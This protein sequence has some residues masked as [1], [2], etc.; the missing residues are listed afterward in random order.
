[1]SKIVQDYIPIDWIFKGTPDMFSMASKEFSISPMSLILDAKLVPNEWDDGGCGKRL[2][3]IGEDKYNSPE[4]EKMRILLTLARCPVEENDEIG[5]YLS[6]ILLD[7]N[8]IG[9][10]RITGE[11]VP[12]IVFVKYIPEG[13]K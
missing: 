7:I 4:E 1:M 10:K 8:K 12:L 6:N 13:S 3:F 9:A 11:E 2:L 5:S